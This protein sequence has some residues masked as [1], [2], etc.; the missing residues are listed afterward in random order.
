MQDISDHYPILF[1][2][3]TQK[4]KGPGTGKGTGNANNYYVHHILM[5]FL[6]IINDFLVNCAFISAQFNYFVIIF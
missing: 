6:G 4:A 5:K 1:E 2:I 3:D